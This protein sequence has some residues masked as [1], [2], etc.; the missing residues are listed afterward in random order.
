MDFL[1]DKRTARNWIAGFHAKNEYGVNCYPEN[2]MVDVMQMSAE[3]VVTYF[4]SLGEHS[5]DEATRTQVIDA[6]AHGMVFAILQTLLV[7][8]PPSFEKPTEAVN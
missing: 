8:T 6:A 1:I 4:R 2:Q 3:M 7:A 5:A